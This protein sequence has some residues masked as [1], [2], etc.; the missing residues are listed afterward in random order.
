MTWQDGSYT[1]VGS[2]ASTGNA[3]S[4]LSIDPAGGELIQGIQIYCY[5]YISMLAIQTNKGQ[6]ISWGTTNN[7]YNDRGKYKETPT[8]C[9]NWSLPTPTYIQEQASYMAKAS[10]DAEYTCHTWTPTESNALSNGQNAQVLC[11]SIGSGP[12]R[13]VF[14]YKPNTIPGCG[15]CSCCAP[16]GYSE[17]AIIAQFGVT[18]PQYLPHNYAAV[19]TT[20]GPGAGTPITGTTASGFLCGLD[21]GESGDY[22]NTLNFIFLL[23]VVNV[24]VPPVNVTAYKSN[25]PPGANLTPKQGEVGNLCSVPGGSV[26]T[27]SFQFEKGSE[28]QTTTTYTSTYALA[29]AYQT[30]GSLAAAVG[31]KEG[32]PGDDASE[33]ITTTATFSFTSTQTNTFSTA[34]ST[35]VTQGKATTYSVDFELVCPA[36]PAISPNTYCTW[37]FGTTDGYQW[38]EPWNNTATFTLIGGQTF[39]QPVSGVI[40]GYEAQSMGLVAIKCENGYSETYPGY[41]NV[42]SS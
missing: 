42:T 38:A 25:D 24:S 41:V 34:S 23:P 8:L 10:P 35:Q 16:V 32:V 30:G 15:G 37:T 14:Q 9:Y 18:E 13:Y 1:E 17:P 39:S 31:G 3:P 19:Q 11:E 27:A 4:C 28:M 2:F 22:V 26:G 33:T 20:Y 7:E 36:A 6:S 29:Q 21:T 12:L 5:N 40:G